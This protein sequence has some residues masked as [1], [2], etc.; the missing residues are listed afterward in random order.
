MSRGESRQYWTEQL[1]EYWDSGFSIQEY[2]ELKD[3]SFENTKRWIRV[4][5]KERNGVTEKSAPATPEVPEPSRLEMVE[6]KP[7]PASPSRSGN[8]GI[9]LKIAGV[10][11]LL[12]RD[13]DGPSLSMLLSVLGER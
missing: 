5:E 7:S 8:S 11:V 1:S 4:F 10:E 12:D 13:F 2:C 3:L 9:R 6:V